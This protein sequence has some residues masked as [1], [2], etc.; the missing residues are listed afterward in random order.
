MILW[1][2]YQVQEMHTISE[3]PAWL[4][5]LLAD[6]V[7]SQKSGETPTCRGFLVSCRLKRLLG[8]LLSLRALTFLGVRAYWFT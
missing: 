2:S 5:F 6:L 7:P 4:T 3:C 8:L 1:W